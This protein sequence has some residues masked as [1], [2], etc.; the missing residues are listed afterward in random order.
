[1]ASKQD[2][3]ED[4]EEDQEKNHATEAAYAEKHD[5]VVGTN[6][7]DEAEAAEDEFECR[8][9]RSRDRRVGRPAS[10]RTVRTRATHRRFTAKVQ[11]HFH[12]ENHT[13]TATPTVMSEWRKL[14]RR[15]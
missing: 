6:W 7:T 15:W 13:S 2:H 9:S 3:E 12:A 8:S 14:I 5:E 4:H 10:W 11:S 1:M